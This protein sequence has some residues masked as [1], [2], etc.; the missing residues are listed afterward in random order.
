MARSKLA[1]RFEPRGGVS[2]SMLDLECKYVGRELDDYLLYS[3]A[4][5]RK[6]LREL[7]GKI[8]PVEEQLQQR[9]AAL[10][11]RERLALRSMV[12]RDLFHV[13]MLY[14]SFI[15]SSPI[16]EATGTATPAS[17]EVDEKTE[18]PKAMLQFKEWLFP[19]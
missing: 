1:R 5:L 12:A 3:L 8:A 7:Q 10:P 16:V 17:E 4:D 19:P 6:K 18:E 11:D 9:L 13:G 14:L 15:R 2:A